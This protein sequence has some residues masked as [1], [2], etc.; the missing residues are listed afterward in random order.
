MLCLRCQATNLTSTCT[1]ELCWRFERDVFEHMALDCHAAPWVGFL[2]HA[3]KC[4]SQDAQAA[5]LGVSERAVPV[6]AKA[7]LLPMPPSQSPPPAECS[8]QLVFSS[9]PPKLARPAS[10]QPRGSEGESSLVVSHVQFA[11]PLYSLLSR[12]SLRFAHGL[13]YT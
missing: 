8:S 2:A 13:K 11:E 3:A 4:E 1:L 7:A 12:V 5:I 10:P 6:L 9:P